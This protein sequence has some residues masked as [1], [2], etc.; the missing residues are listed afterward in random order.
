MRKETNRNPLC[1]ETM[2]EAYNKERMILKQVKYENPDFLSLCHELD[3]FLNQA[4]GGEDK[5]EKYKKFNQ[6]DTLDYV[7]VAYVD[8]KPV[9]CGALRRYSEDEIEVKRLFVQEAFRGSHIGALVLEDLIGRAEQMA[10]KRMILET[11]VFLS[12][13]VRLYERYGFERIENYGAYKDMPE[14]LCMGRGIGEDAIYYCT[15]RWIA[16][17]DLR[18]LFASV[19]W[20]SAQYADRLVK[21]VQKAGTV[22][23]AWQNQRLIGLIE[24]LDDGELTAYVHYLL[25]HPQYQHRGIAGH[26]LDAVKEIYHEYLYLILLSEKESTIPFYEKYDFALIEGSTPMQIRH[27]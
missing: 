16:A 25:V 24:V 11:G 19:G 5:R 4:I 17:D 12:L 26:M 15:G 20:L 22:I 10:Y 7:V 21:A 1:E 27:L 8:D 13:S 3:L 18:E 6:P 9:G 23:S 2:K 14:S